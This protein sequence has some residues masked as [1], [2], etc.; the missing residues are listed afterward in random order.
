MTDLSFDEKVFAALDAAPY[1]LSLRELTQRVQEAE[2]AVADALERLVAGGRVNM[3]ADRT[4]RAY[5]TK[6]E[7]LF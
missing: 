2:S 7:H 4:T 3:T 1:A 5:Y 6:A